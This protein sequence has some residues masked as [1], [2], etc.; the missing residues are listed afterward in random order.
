[1]GTEKSETREE[2][3]KDEAGTIPG[4][5]TCTW[6]PV[7]DLPPVQ[8]SGEEVGDTTV[9]YSGAEEASLDP[10]VSLAFPDEDDVPDGCGA[11]ILFDLGGPPV[12]GPQLWEINVGG[13]DGPSEYDADPSA[14][15][16]PE[17]VCAD[18]AEAAAMP[19][20]QS[21]S[22]VAVVP[23]FTETAYLPSL[24]IWRRMLRLI[25]FGRWG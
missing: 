10:N 22:S 7:P 18:G 12:G 5:W 4:G 21:D 1:M 13:Q 6:E 11:A 2:G 15:T 14:E 3:R 9:D 24:P 19:E 25:T 16:P 8:I 23:D 20:D 17:D